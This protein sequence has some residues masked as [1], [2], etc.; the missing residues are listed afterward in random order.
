MQSPKSLSWLYRESDQCGGNLNAASIFD[1]QN[2]LSDDEAKQIYRYMTNGVELLTFVSPLQDPINP[3]DVLPMIFYSDGVYFWNSVVA[4]WVKRNRIRLP[5]E[6][7]EH[8]LA[9]KELPNSRSDL[10]PIELIPLI[11][12]AIPLIIKAEQ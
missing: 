2:V 4:N 1:H 10:D 7:M 6:F 3:Q 12:H 5:L 9:A 11:N 8:A